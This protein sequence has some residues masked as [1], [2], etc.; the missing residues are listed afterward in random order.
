[1]AVLSHA[2]SNYDQCTGE[3]RGGFESNMLLRTS[4]SPQPPGAR[5]GLR[6]EGP[7]AEHTGFEVNVALPNAATAL[8]GLIPLVPLAI[9]EAEHPIL[10]G[11]HRIFKAEH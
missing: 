4:R 3:L 2:V 9:G 10:K 1:M 11:E 5:T 7:R 6:P 8:R